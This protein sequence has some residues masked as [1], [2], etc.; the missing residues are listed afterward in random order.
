MIGGPFLNYGTDRVVEIK[1]LIESTVDRQ[2]HLLELAEA[3]VSADRLLLSEA[4]GFSLET[5]YERIPEVLKG[6]V[7]LVYDLNNQPSLR[8]IEGLLYRSPFYDESRQ[9]LD[10]SLASGDD[11]SF[12]LSTPRL[13][14]PG[15]LHLRIP[16]KDKRLDE[17]FAMRSRAGDYARVRELLEIREDQDRL[18]SSFFDTN[19]ARPAARYAGDGIR[20]RYF[21][22][23]CVLIES[24]SVAIMT[25]PIVS[26][27]ISDGVPR[28]SYADLPEVIDYVLLTHN[29]QDHCMIETLLQLRH[30]IGQVVVPRNSG[31]TL[32]DPSLKR[33]LE[34]IGFDNV[35][36]LD[37]IET[38]ALPGGEVTALPFLGEHGDLN[39]RTKAGYFVNLAG[40]S[41]MA[42]ADSNNLEP[43]VYD[44]IKKIVGDVD[45]LFIGMECSGAPMSWIYGALLSGTVARKMDQSRRLNG[46]DF[47]KASGIVDRFLPKQVYVYAMGQEPWLKHIV[48][49]TYNERST[50]IVESTRLVGYCREK[51]IESERLFV[52]KEIVLA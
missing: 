4:K 36:E 37:E 49:I 10:L 43:R 44:H 23:A 34:T 35:R 7:E 3:L 5:M 19:V 21:G 48:A 40:K 15:H 51:N 8:I 11:R 18:F 39:I 42:V 1:D 41:V 31:G 29:H 38:I 50:P 16:F 14:A 25:D 9:S 32:A 28:Y 22:H 2:A 6:Y 30:R 17:L 20:I 26:Y 47:Q 33:V 46:S 27:A 13:D 24:R 45:V 12:V 52:Q